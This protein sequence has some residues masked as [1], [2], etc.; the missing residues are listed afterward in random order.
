MMQ[1]NELA[2][3]HQAALADALPLITVLVGKADGTLD[4]E[5]QDYAEKVAYYRQFEF[6]ES[7]NSY[8]VKAHENFDGRVDAL[9]AEL[10]EELE[11]RQAIISERLSKLNATLATLEPTYAKRLVASW[12]TF[13]EY[14]AKAS[15]GFMGFMSIGPEERKAIE[16]NMLQY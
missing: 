6:P 5:E 14:V 11:A 3:E 10:P 13:A 1:Y 9:E 2:A 4:D 15:G 7:L 16:L 8:Y 12:R